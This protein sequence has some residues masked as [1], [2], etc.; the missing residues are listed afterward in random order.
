MKLR[1]TVLGA[2][3]LFRVGPR[4]RTVDWGAY[5]RDVV[6]NTDFRKFDGSVRLVLAGTEAQRERLDA[7][8]G[9]LREAGEVSYGMHVADSAL[10]TCLVD[11]RQGSHFHFVDAA[12]GGYAAAAMNLEAGGIRTPS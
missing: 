6:V 4:T 2:E 11:Q 7:F 5:K 12:G 8:L 1:A 9:S 10:M 3:I